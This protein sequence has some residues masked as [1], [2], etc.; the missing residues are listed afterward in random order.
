MY[1]LYRERR[2]NRVHRVVCIF[3]HKEA[4]VTGDGVKNLEIQPNTFDVKV[5]SKD[6]Q[7]NQTYT[8]TVNR[9]AKSKIA[10]LQSLTASVG[11][12]SPVFNADSTNYFVDTYGTASISFDAV[13]TQ[14]DAQ[15]DGLGNH[16]LD[17]RSSSQLLLLQKMGQ[18]PRLIR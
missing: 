12:M 2:R 10:T 15:I 17:G 5:Q 9:A 14:E 7:N 16:P 4:T 13:K 1:M 11:F 6:G 18:L 3:T 8:V